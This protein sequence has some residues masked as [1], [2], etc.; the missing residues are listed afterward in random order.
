MISYP[1]IGF[2]LRLSVGSAVGKKCM[3]KISRTLPLRS[4]RMRARSTACR[5]RPFPPLPPR[6]SGSASSTNHIR[7]SAPHAAP[8]S[9][10]EDDKLIYLGVRGDEVLP[11]SLSD[12]HV[13]LWK[14]ILIA[15]TKAETVHARYHPRQVWR[16]AVCRFEVRV[17]AHGERERRLGLRRD[18]RGKGRELSSS[19]RERLEGQVS[20]LATVSEVGALTW[21]PHMAQAVQAARARAGQ[22]G[23]SPLP[24]NRA[25]K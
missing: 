25:P 24:P 10:P 16:Q 21:V 4:L 9:F 19:H 6:M 2:V 20:P 5:R 11:G 8:R 22:P 1:E 14:F 7:L 17:R 3:K 12:L 18:C 13:I 23:G 15:F